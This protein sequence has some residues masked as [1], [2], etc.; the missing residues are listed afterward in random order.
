MKRYRAGFVRAL[1]ISAGV[2]TGVVALS[3][4]GFQSPA[5]Q[6][7]QRLVVVDGNDQVARIGELLPVR[8]TVLAADE[9]G[10]PLPDA[11]VIIRVASGGGLAA[12]SRLRT[13]ASGH[14][15][16]LWRLGLQTGTQE[17]TASLP[18]VEALVTFT[19]TAQP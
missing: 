4:F 17:L 5:N 18:N 13:D 15:S 14:A 7:A 12:P 1:T 19:A 3:A 8:L 16:M 6:Q 11:E 10:A 2:M 9:A